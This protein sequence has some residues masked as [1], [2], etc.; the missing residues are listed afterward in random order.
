MADLRYIGWEEYGRLAEA[1]ANK[2]IS[3]SLQFELVIGIARGGIPLAMVV[4]DR[5]GVKLDIVNVKSYIAINKRKTPK[6]VSTL[7]EKIKGKTILLVD[8]LVDNGDTM[9]TVIDYLKDEG[10][11]DIKTAVLFKKPWSKFQPDFFIELVTQWIVF[12]WEVE[13][14]KRALLSS[15][16]QELKEV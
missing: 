8:D 9:N 3:S 5:L 6:I 13:E 11:L 4:A 7:T 2:I 15:E 16:S 10:P 14:V 1:L 12:P